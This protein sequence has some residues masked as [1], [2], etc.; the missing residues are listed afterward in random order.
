M[1]KLFKHYELIA[2]KYYPLGIV[3]IIV[4][5]L[6]IIFSFGLPCGEDSENVQLIKQRG[7]FETCRAPAG[8]GDVDKDGIPN[9][10]DPDDDND[11]IRDS[12]DNCFPIANPDQKDSDG[13]GLGDVCDDNFDRDGVPDSVDNCPK[14]K[15][16]NQGDFDKDGRGDACDDDIDGDGIPNTKDLCNFDKR[17]TCAQ[18]ILRN[19]RDSKAAKVKLP[20]KKDT[21]G[22]G[23]PDSNDNCPTVANKDQSDIDADGIGDACDPCPNDPQ[24]DEDG[25][26]VCGNIDNC[27][28]TPNP[29]QEDFDG[30]N[31]GDACDSDVDG[32]G[33]PNDTDNCM[34]VS[35]PSQADK[36]GDGIGDACDFVDDTDSDEDGL[37]DEKDNCPDMYNLAQ[38]DLDNDGIG[39][40]CDNCPQTANSGQED[41][42]GDTIGDACDTTGTSN[43]GQM[44]QDFCNDLWTIVKEECGEPPNEYMYTV[45]MNT[46]TDNCE[47]YYPDEC[48]DDQGTVDAVGKQLDDCLTQQ[49]DS[50][51]CEE[52]YDPSNN[53]NLSACSDQF[54][55]IVT[56]CS[57]ATNEEKM[58]E[59]FCEDLWTKTVA[60]C[61]TEP[62]DSVK[63]AYIKNCTNYCEDLYPEDCPTDDATTSQIETQLNE[64]VTKLTSNVTCDPSNP[65]TTVAWDV[66]EEDFNTIVAICT[67]SQEE[68][69]TN[70]DDSI[71][72]IEAYELYSIDF[73]IDENNQLQYKNFLKHVHS[74]TVYANRYKQALTETHYLLKGYDLF[75]NLMYESYLNFSTPIIEP[76]EYHECTS[77]TD[78]PETAIPVDDTLYGGALIPST[79]GT[80]VLKKIIIETD[81]GVKEFELDITQAILVTQKDD[82]PNENSMVSTVLKM[83]F[84]KIAEAEELKNCCQIMTEECVENN[85]G[86]EIRNN[87]PL[88]A[89]YSKSIYCMIDNAYLK[90]TDL[91][92]T[93]LTKE[94]LHKYVEGFVFEDM[95]ETTKDKTAAYYHGY[96]R[97]IHIIFNK[98]GNTYIPLIDTP[99]V[100]H[101]FGHGWEETSLEYNP[102]TKFGYTFYENAWEKTHKAHGPGLSIL[103]S[104]AAC[105]Y[106]ALGIAHEDAAEWFK[107]YFTESDPIQN[108]FN[109]GL[110]NQSERAYYCNLDMSTKKYKGWT[111]MPAAG[112]R[113]YSGLEKL[114]FMKD[115]LVIKKNI[116][117]N[118][119]KAL[120]WSSCKEQ[121]TPAAHNANQITTETI[122]SQR[123]PLL[124]EWSVILGTIPDPKVITGSSTPEAIAQCQSTCNQKQGKIGDTIKIT[125]GDYSLPDDFVGNMACTQLDV[126]RDELSTPEWCQ[127]QCN[128]PHALFTIDNQNMRGIPVVPGD[129][130][131]KCEYFKQWEITCPRPPGTT[132]ADPQYDA[133]IQLD[134]S[135]E[136]DAFFHVMNADYK[137]A[138]AVAHVGWDNNQQGNAYC[139]CN[140]N[141]P[142]TVTR[143]EPKSGQENTYYYP[144]D[145]C[146]WSNK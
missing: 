39:D 44:C 20:A 32:D 8:D 121:A 30:D 31:I 18:A 45:F 142:I 99:G 87:L 106:A 48:P 109:Q 108:S 118:I 52:I 112:C 97:T 47:Y 115:T 56:I 140:W 133:V 98:S 105:S 61:E 14:V 17:N 62:N 36:D 54:Q 15:N 76:A 82:E 64:C 113:N 24:N 34:Y 135:D 65:P 104:Y 93:D 145:Q 79:M 102:T 127:P 80:Q 38:S 132:I 94:K 46:C 73:W 43:Q 7:M 59:D 128:N 22:D 101:E 6:I 69:N 37:P 29:Y 90:M 124:G 16:H 75:G 9:A 63:D 117:Q 60:T 1:L 57:A 129:D 96:R 19:K 138:K 51:N 116:Y 10:C 126:K 13:D 107:A 67:E 131:K 144:T 53:V 103:D 146:N 114:T 122:A 141:Y 2:R 50:L 3:L 92:K 42:D 95:T 110:L 4:S 84:E 100:I 86:I 83:Q 25:D 40:A 21:D 23:K 81:A 11:G 120:S 33:R 125:F 130:E 74:Y 28:T 35:N 88:N 70:I 12:K 119:A 5:L 134:S 41:K 68:D 58:C 123:C 27:K 136:P 77:E 143:K 72:L 137:F 66:C 85:W 111:A 49:K 91:T 89:V 55:E 26:N 139:E 71:E 78:C